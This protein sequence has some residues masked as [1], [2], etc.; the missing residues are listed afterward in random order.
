MKRV[1]KKKNIVKVIL[2]EQKELP[3]NQRVIIKNFIELS[4]KFK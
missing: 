3:D 1:K 2:L 4:G